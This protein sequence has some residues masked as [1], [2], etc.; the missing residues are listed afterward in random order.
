MIIGDKVKVI[1]SNEINYPLSGKII[2]QD[3]GEKMS[4]VKFKI[5]EVWYLNVN[6]QKE[7]KKKTGE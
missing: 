6:L 2:E 7:K 4:K 3:E 1:N 5:S